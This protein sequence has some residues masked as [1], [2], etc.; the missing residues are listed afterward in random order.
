MLG[1]DKQGALTDDMS[2]IGSVMKYVQMWLQRSSSSPLDIV[3][4][5]STPRTLADAEME[6]AFKAIISEGHRWRNVS[7]KNVHRRD[8][9]G[10]PI[11]IAS[12]YLASLSFS[13]HPFFNRP[14]LLDFTSSPH[15]H[16]LEVANA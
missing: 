11:S 10:Q 5:T 6:E 12:E 4:E 13:G 16:S 15:L 7:L 14:F 9:V 2:G 3:L 1:E 8:L